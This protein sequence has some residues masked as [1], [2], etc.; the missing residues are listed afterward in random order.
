M[1][2]QDRPGVVR[3]YHPDFARQPSFR[4]VVT[5]YQSRACQGYSCNC[6]TCAGV[7]NLYK[8]AG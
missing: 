1:C 5:P 4:D 6:T 3:S 2:E 7:H 8:L